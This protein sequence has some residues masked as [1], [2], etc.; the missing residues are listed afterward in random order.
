LLTI[1]G[2]NLGPGAKVNGQLDG[3]GRLPFSLA[4]STVF[5]DDIPAPLIS[6]QDT[7]IVCFAPFEISQATRVSV[8]FGGQQS[9]LV[10]VGVTIN[11]PQILSIANA[12]GTFN[13]ADNPAAPGSVVVIY[14]S[15]FGLT[16]PASV[17][18]LRN[19]SSPAALTTP[20]IVHFP[21]GNVTPQFAGSAPGMVAGITQINVAIPVASYASSQVGINVNN[22]AATVYVKQ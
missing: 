3:S 18:G 22:A 9:N 15:G 13:S 21:A 10:R 5:F 4:N 1:K 2:R 11:D 19:T 17:D 14:A 20:V 7:A 16:R 12:D 6:V 8:V